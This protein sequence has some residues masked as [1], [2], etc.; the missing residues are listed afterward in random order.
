[1]PSQSEG[2]GGVRRE[3]SGVRQGWL[4]SSSHTLL[5]N[6]HWFSE[7]FLVPQQTVHV[8]KLVAAL[9]LST[10]PLSLPRPWCGGLGTGGSLK[11]KQ[12]QIVCPPAGMGSHC[13]RGLGKKEQAS[14][15]RVLARI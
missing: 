3:E 1:M 13:N 8:E 7:T 14:K 12:H 11:A 5:S 9:K 6:E 2:G 4:L 10:L 15:I